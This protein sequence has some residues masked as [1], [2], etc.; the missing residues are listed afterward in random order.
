[1]EDNVYTHFLWV[2]QYVIK[3][4]Y[5]FNSQRVRPPP[6]PIFQEPAT[7]Y[8]YCLTALFVWTCYRQLQLHGQFTQ[9]NTRKYFEKCFLFL[10]PSWNMATSY[11]AWMRNEFCLFLQLLIRHVLVTRSSFTAG[12][13]GAVASNPIDVVK[14]ICFN[15][16]FKK[17]Q[18]WHGVCFRLICICVHCY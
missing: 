6:P 2:Y 12:F 7:E 18:I 5:R 4:G 17:F 11:S 3:Y 9:S 14:V 8:D 13:A 1:M 15:D 16:I 10:L